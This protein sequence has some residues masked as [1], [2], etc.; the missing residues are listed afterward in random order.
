MRLARTKKL[1]SLFMRQDYLVFFSKLPFETDFSKGDGE[2]SYPLKGNCL[3]FLIYC[4][5]Q[6]FTHV[7]KLM[8]QEN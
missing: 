3:C 7:K 2:S 5:P 6:T 1:E 4:N 8:K